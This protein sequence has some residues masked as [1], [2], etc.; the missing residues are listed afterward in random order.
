MAKMIRSTEESYRAA[1]ELLTAFMG[2][3]ELND[4]SLRTA[5]LVMADYLGDPVPKELQSAA[6][7]ITGL[8]SLLEVL[9]NAETQLLT[10]RKKTPVTVADVLASLG[11]SIPPKP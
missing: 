3:R 2:D 11:R 5:R 7:L 9:V 8:L 10:E 1:L 4:T 6:L